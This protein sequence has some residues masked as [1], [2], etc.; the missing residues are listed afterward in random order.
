MAPAAVGPFLCSGVGVRL[1]GQRQRPPSPPPLERLAL[2]ST[3][4]A[5]A[6][7]PQETLHPRMSRRLHKRLVRTQRAVVTGLSADRVAA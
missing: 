5:E 1:T 3:P 7:R 6:P 4:E 2:P